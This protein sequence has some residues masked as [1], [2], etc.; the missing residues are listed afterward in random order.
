MEPRRAL[1]C[2]GVVLL[3]LMMATAFTGYVLPWGQMSLWG[4]TVI[5]RMVT[6]I[7]VAGI[8]ILEWMWG[9]YTV[10][11]PT[12]YRFYTV[13]FVLPFLIIGMT[14]IHLILLHRVGSSD[15]AASDP[16][17]DDIPFYPYMFSKD[18][19]AFFIYLFVFA[20]MVFYY[21]NVLNHPDN[22]VPANP[23]KT[24]PHVVPEWYF[25]PYYAIL[26]SFTTKTGGILG[27]FF[28]LLVLFLIPFSNSSEV[29]N[30]T[31]R[32]IFKFFFWLFMIDFFFCFGLVKNL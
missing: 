16:N 15:T 26:R 11:K 2:S 21:P 29:R 1:W 17:L 28:S 25:L 18:L 14:L 3:L 9:G 7:P 24:P 10:S 19:F 8:H 6:I 22:Y 30:T 31:Y 13:H 4:A 5:T 12:L 27:M 20:I 32:P 23:M